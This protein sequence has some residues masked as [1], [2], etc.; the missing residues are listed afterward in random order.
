MCG[1]VSACTND[2]EC[3][4]VCESVQER[5]SVCVSVRER[6]ESVVVCV[7]VYFGISVQAKMPRTYRHTHLS[8]I[9]I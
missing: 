2:R 6:R 1:H 8:L 9:H 5:L 4:S 7:S 3:V